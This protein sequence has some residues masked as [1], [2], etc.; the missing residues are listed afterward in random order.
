MGVRLSSPWGAAGFPRDISYRTTANLLSGRC[1]FYP[2]G[3]RKALIRLI[4]S[5]AQERGF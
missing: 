5:L 2:Y 4:A 3:E 1:V